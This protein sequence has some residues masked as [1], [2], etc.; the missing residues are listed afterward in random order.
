MEIRLATV[1]D[2]PSY[3][4]HMRRHF[5]E[6]GEGGDLIFHPVV[7][8]ESWRKEEQ[9]PKLFDEWSLAP[10]AIGWQK[11]WIAVENGEIVA[12]CLLRSGQMPATA[13]RCQYAIG[14]ERAYRGKGLGRRLSMLALSWAKL[15]P[16]LEWVDLWVFAHNAGAIRLYESFGFEKV[17]TVNDQ[18]RVNGKKIDDLHMTMRLKPHV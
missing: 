17:D 10:P 11:V 1:D 18:F 4:D 7:E 15:E 9:V 13:H 3:F 16:G 14:I 2:I 12:D 6:S 5:A 8:F